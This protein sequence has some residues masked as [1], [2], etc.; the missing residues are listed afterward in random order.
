ML[1]QRIISAVVLIVAVLIALIW[2]SPFYLALTLGVVVTLGVWEWTQFAQIKT[3]FWRLLIAGLVG[4]FLFIWIFGE[5][6]YL[7][8]GRVFENYSALLLLSSVLWWAAA[9][10]FVVNYPNSANI[11]GKSAFLQLIFLFSL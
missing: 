11:W 8:V 9:L 3:G 7:R 10:I 4:C 2:F 1:K 6:R 5:A